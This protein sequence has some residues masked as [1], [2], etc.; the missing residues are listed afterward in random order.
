MSRLRQSWSLLVPALV[1]A[2]AV[3]MQGVGYFRAAPPPRTPHLEQT[4]PRQVSGW[5]GRDVP[6]GPNE[7]VAGEVEKILRYDEVVNREFRRGNETFGVYV[8]YW[9]EGKM[10]SQLVASH[11]PDRCW[12]ENGWRCL[13]MKFKQPL[14]FEG[15]P[16]LPAEWRVFAPPA[17]S[18]P[19]Y[20]LY[21]HLND[22]QLYDYGERF[23]AVPDPLRWWQDVARQALRGNREQYFVRLTSNV[24]LESLWSDPGLAEI[25]RGLGRLGLVASTPSTS[26]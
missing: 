10:P 4:I 7:F 9:G 11:T 20:V 25:L 1:L 6:L 14:R 22:G 5:T 24:P 18:E 15:D 17:T 3:S 21:W 16:L 8:A 26:S 2:V 19:T 23:N 13:E 12:T